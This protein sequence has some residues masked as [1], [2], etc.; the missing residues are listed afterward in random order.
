MSINVPPQKNV[1]AGEPVTAEGWNSLVGGITAIVTFLEATEASGARVVIKNTGLVSARV[2]AVRD[3]GVT[4]DAVSPVPPGT[5]Y[6]FAG[7][8]PGS[9]AVRVEAAGFS[10]ATATLTAPAEAP[11][12]ISLSP[13][14]AFMPDVFGMT[15]RAALQELSTRAI[16]VGR[17]VDVVGRDVAPAN[18]GAEYL[19]QPVLMQ[20]PAAGIAGPPESQPQLVVATTLQVTPSVEMP[21]LTGLTLA[22]AK[23]ALEAIGLS[24]GKVETK[25]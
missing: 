3:D 9:Y 21:S 10:P 18:P 12:E 23:K 16:K 22:E 25:T 19:D 11:L 24:L 1:S 15:I 17:I 14:G 8:R 2:S 5:E 7:L 20:L 4:F 6:I 13:N